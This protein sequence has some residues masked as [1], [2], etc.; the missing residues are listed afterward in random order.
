MKNFFKIILIIFGCA[1][2]SFLLLFLIAIPLAIFGPSDTELDSASERI[3]EIQ[4][5]GLLA[6]VFLFFCIRVWKNTAAT[7]EYYKDQESSEE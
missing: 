7:L 1:L 3:L 2:E 5:Y 6:L 4:V